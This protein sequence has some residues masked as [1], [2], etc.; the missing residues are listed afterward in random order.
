[1]SNL[2]QAIDHSLSISYRIVFL[3]SGYKKIC[4]RLFNNHCQT[5]KQ[6]L[7]LFLSQNF[8][9][10]KVWLVKE[11]AQNKHLQISNSATAATCHD[12]RRGNN[13]KEVLQT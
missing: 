5:T 3:S 4:S 6:L 10:L 8:P 9:S 13:Q 1:V 7:E 11:Q 2:D 12:V